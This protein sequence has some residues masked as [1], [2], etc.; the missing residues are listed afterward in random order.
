[1]LDDQAQH[2]AYLIGQVKARSATTVEPS[3]EAEAEW[4]AT[5]KQ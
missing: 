3:A 1:M 2:L 5:I 4:V